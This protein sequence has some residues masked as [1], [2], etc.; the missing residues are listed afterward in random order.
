MYGGSGK[1]GRG[2]G[3]G[4]F[5]RNIHS[6]LHPSP[7]QRPSSAAAPSGRLSTG[8]A[9]AAP[10]NRTASASVGGAAAVSAGSTEESFSLVTGNPLNFGMIIRL[11]PDLVEEIK[12]VESQGS[13]ARIKFDA[14]ANNPA[15][16]VIKVGGKDF[17]F[18]WSRD[19]GDLCDIYE[20]R[21][22]GEDGN[23]L[24]VESGCA[25]R[26][27]TVQRVLDESTKN[28]V[29]MLSEEAERKLKL[30]RSIVLDPGNP[31][32]KSQMK[33]LAAAESNPR[34]MKGAPPFKKRKAEPPP[35][36]PPKS[37][38][39]SGLTTTPLSK[40]RPPISPPPPAQSGPLGSPF[41]S[42]NLIKGHANV[43]DIV[44]SQAN[45]KAVSSEKDTTGKVIISADRGKPEKKGTI[46]VQ[47]IDLRS[48]LISLLKE[49]PSKGMSF[50]AIE[51]AIGDAIP[52]SVRQIEPILKKIATFQSPGIYFLK[53][54]VDIESFKKPLSEGQSSPEDNRHPSPANDDQQSA[55]DT[56]FPMISDTN[57]LE[58][59]AE[60][61]SKYEE[62][63]TSLTKGGVL[64]HSTVLF[65]EKRVSDS[66][67]GPVGSSGGGVSDSDSDSESDSSGSGS[68]SKSQSRSPAGSGSGSSSDSE[69]DASTNSK[70]AS[71]EEVDIMTSDDDNQTKHR[72][73]ASGLGSSKSPLLW[74]TSDGDPAHIGTDEKQDGNVC[75]VIEIEKDLPEDQ[76][77]GGL[78]T[79]C[80]SVPNKEGE[81][82]VE[83][84]TPSLYYR[85]EDQERQD[86]I[87]KTYRETGNVA[88]DGLNHGQSNSS[89]KASRGK[90]KRVSDEKH[91]DDKSDCS[92]R[93]KSENSHQP[94]V[95]GSRTALFEDSHQPQVSGSRTVL[96]EDIH[97]NSSPN[98]PFEDLHKGPNN[99]M[100]NR[101]RR[102]ANPSF[103]SQKVNVQTSSTKSMLD[104]QQPIQRFVDRSAHA[105]TS[106]SVERLGKH[107]E[108]TGRGVRHP[109]RL[110]Q[111]NDDVP[112]QKDK[113]NREMQD[114]YGSVNYEG[115]VKVSKE[116]FGEKYKAPVDS[117]QRKHEAFGNL[118]EFG[119]V[120]NSHVGYSPKDENTNSRDRSVVNGRPNLLQRELSDLELGEL[121]EP[122][123]EETPGFS[124]ELDRKSFFKQLENKTLSSENW[125]SDPS[126]AKLASKMTADSR[127][128]SSLNTNIPVPGI[129]EGIP[130]RGV[131]EHSAEDLSRPHQRAEQSHQ[132]QHQSRV[133]CTDAGTQHNR[134]VELS[135]RN[136]RREV[137]RIDSTSEVHRNFPSKGSATASQE[138]DAKQGS[139][140]P[141]RKESRR[142]K[143]SAVPDLNDKKQDTSLTGSSDGCQRRRESS[144]DENSFPYSKYEKDEPELKE[145]IKDGF[146]YKEYVE[147][148]Q[149]KYGIYCSLN[150]ILESYREEFLKFGRELEASKGKDMERYYDVER[151]M[152]ESFRCCGER[153][154]RMKKIF[155]VLHEE[156]EHLKRMIEEFA[157][158]YVKDLKD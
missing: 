115:P 127:K 128:S 148:F 49:S 87:R 133:D 58:E 99:Q 35:G 130:N 44:S 28:H 145:P 153:F 143:F 149:E 92:K 89:E 3:G 104:S 65:G 56:S 48:M 46:G 24:L 139:A 25:W 83:E 112:M 120:L 11:A 154:K 101:M 158:P 33:A 125:N 123:P 19:T 82:P 21:Q 45:S 62:A 74:R 63:P 113:F 129:S 141:S 140:P 1:F 90:Y 98:R 8:G 55:P 47:P 135:G 23:G 27:L 136:R 109:E 124:K 121:R 80:E 75:D 142:Q 54:G 119:S 116:D 6:T 52:N 94:Q 57:E 51:K 77:V 32:M 91:V 14:N 131:P 95:S 150:K 144:S 137:G 156:L 29:K 79:A 34:R 22:S 4:G 85:H 5:K 31:T 152:K 97:Q 157:A 39:K 111:M 134:V 146:R 53:P 72:L 20:E 36:G 151:Q 88:K 64:Y 16:N 155:V 96:F 70:E 126:K 108:Y 61:D 2:G 138:H 68:H 17:R 147:E 84:T 102:E 12:R 86:H 7:L 132:W 117:S 67:E 78:A 15:G 59:Q 107:S 105:K 40:G 26:K 69:S 9:G 66:R 103:G 76:S 100:A 41:G 106:T 10:G 122:L 118:K 43:E 114:E 13:V 18:M 30:R 50:K 38:H 37:V 110:H 42:G 71:D 73:Q 60:L 93:L 81:K